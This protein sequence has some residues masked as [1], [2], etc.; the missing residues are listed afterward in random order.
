MIYFDQEAPDSVSW[1]WEK[2]QGHLQHRF[3]GQ[4]NK[5]QS[6]LLCLIDILPTFTLDS[7]HSARG[8]LTP[9]FLLHGNMKYATIDEHRA[10]NIAYVAPH[11]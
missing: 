7:R 9:I 1:R 3:D 4:F 6:I 8:P 11:W 2:T 5:K 10:V